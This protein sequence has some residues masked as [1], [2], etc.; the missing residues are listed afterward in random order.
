MVPAGGPFRPTII[1][2]M[3]VLP[4]PDSP[5]IAR[6]R[7]GG[8]RTSRRRRRRARRTPCAGPAASRTGVAGWRSG[9]G[10]PGAGRAAR[11]RERSGRAPPSRLAP[12]AGTSARQ[13]SWACGQRGANAH[14]AGRL[15]GRQRA[16]GD[17][18]EAVR[19]RG[20]VGAG[21]GQGGGVGMQR[22]AVQQPAPRVSTICPAYI[23]QVRSQ[24][25]AASSRSW[26]MNSIARP[27]SRRSS[28]RIAITSA[29][30]VTSRAVVGSSASNR[31][32]SDE[33]GR[34][35]HDALEHPAG[36]LV[37]VLAR[38]AGRRPRC[39]PRR[40][41]RPRGGAPRRWHVVEGAQGLG[42]EVADPPHRI[43]VRPRVLEDHRH[44]AHPPGRARDDRRPVGAHR[45]DARRGAGGAR[46]GPGAR[47][48]DRIRRGRRG[49]RERGRSAP[50]W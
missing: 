37:R 46:R 36:E 22:V 48:R 28:S 44:L 41:P 42:H 6:D 25:A 19:G 13:A 17:G 2:A 26:V 4:E 39:R 38:G 31:R 23:T 11:R 34:R 14:P 29:W 43:D 50:T 3:V 7:P 20:D 21:R 40:A 15:E 30:V 49:A 47:A 12:A 5:T 10:P 24:T 16:A 18:R 33:Q 1:R 32:G 8:R 9:T 35:D 45:R 27:Q